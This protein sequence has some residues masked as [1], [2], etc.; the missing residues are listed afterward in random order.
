VRQAASNGQFTKNILKHR[1]FGDGF[2][3]RAISLNVLSPGHTGFGVS[4]LC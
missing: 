1:K 3:R 2:W 4:W